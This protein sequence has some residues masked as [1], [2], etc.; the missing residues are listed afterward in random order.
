[1]IHKWTNIRTVATVCLSILAVCM[2]QA[3]RNDI[4]PPDSADT[5]AAVEASSMRMNF[6]IG[7]LTGVAGAEPSGEAYES[8]IDVDARNYRIYFFDTSDKFIAEFN[9]LYVDSADE[10]GY[11]DYTLTGRIAPVMGQYKDFKV[12]VLANWPSYPESLQ[13]GVTTVA[14]VCEDVRGMFRR[15]D[16]ASAEGG[17][18][19]FF[20]IRSFAGVEHSSVRGDI[21]L[22]Q[23][24]TLIRAVAKI[25][26]ELNTDKTDGKT[27]L[28]E[29]TLTGYNEGGYCA[30]DDVKSHA[31]YGEPICWKRAGM[32]PVHLYGSA[33]E[34]AAA[35]RTIPFREAARDDS[36]RVTRW[37]LYVPEYI[38]LEADGTPAPDDRRARIYVGFT[39]PASG[40][41][42]IDFKFHSDPVWPGTDMKK[43]D[44]FNIKRNY[45]YTFSLY[46]SKDRLDVVTDVAPYVDVELR[47][48]FGLVRDEDTGML[49]IGKYAPD[50]YYYDDDMLRYYDAEG[51]EMAHRVCRDAEGRYMVRDFRSNRFRYCYDDAAR[52]YY[53]DAECTVLLESPEQLEFPINSEGQLIIRTNDF[54][55]AIYFWNTARGE[56]LDENGSVVPL[57]CFAFQRWPDD[58]RYIVI[59]YTD[60]GRYRLLYAPDTDRY[61]RIP[62]DGGDLE[63]MQAF[64]PKN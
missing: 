50:I 13:T 7:L 30:P 64:P 21:E 53:A 26:V 52:R 36:G 14:D 6:R 47:P 60:Q 56:C 9:P 33:N 63:E 34:A 61:Y 58:E 57:P 19:P 37:E 32:Q 28:T 16:I 11:R 1:M 48:G 24:V 42:Y 23:P 18:I 22:A 15:A 41:Q 59:D 29:V 20:G 44:H 51:R 5:P 49:I 27:E 54:G 3:C 55:E 38:N 40:S 31:D 25:V 43:G 12:M 45:L 46:K 62:D 10:E 17:Y 8:F 4:T 39:G 35:T 2:L